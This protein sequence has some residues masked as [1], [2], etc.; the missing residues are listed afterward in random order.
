MNQFKM[1]TMS[2][3]TDLAEEAS[4]GTSKEF[5]IEERTINNQ[6]VKVQV[7]KECK[8]RPKVFGKA[9]QTRNVKKS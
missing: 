5:T 3:F 9:K 2:M 7:Y 4:E 1:P 6:I 8:K